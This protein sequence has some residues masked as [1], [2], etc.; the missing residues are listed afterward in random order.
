VFG[1]GLR[2]Q[3]SVDRAVAEG[4][5]S[6]AD[7]RMLLALTAAGIVLAALTVVLLITSL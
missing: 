6:P 4:G 5:F 1:Y 7:P 3:L 2:R